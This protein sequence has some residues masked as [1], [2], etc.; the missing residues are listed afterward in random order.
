MHIHAFLNCFHQV[1]AAS[2]DYRMALPTKRKRTE[3]THAIK[4]K[5]CRLKVDR[6]KVTLAEIKDIIREENGLDLGTSTIGD[7]IRESDVWLAI[8]ESDGSSSACR[9]RCPRFL[10]LEDSLFEWIMERGPDSITD[11]ALLEEAK[12]IGRNLQVD[13]KFGY[14]NGWLQRFKQ[15]RGLFHRRQQP[16]RYPK[17]PHR[18]P[19]RPPSLTLSLGTLTEH[20]TSSDDSFFDNVKV[21]T[22]VEDPV[23]LSSYVMPTSGARVTLAQAT[24]AVR[25]VSEYFS[26]IS[27]SDDEEFAMQRDSVVK[28]LDAI[29]AILKRRSHQRFRQLKLTQYFTPC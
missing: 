13:P 4:A 1:P 6:P 2:S 14:S 12:R 5:I 16:P 26:Q 21:K 18:K 25:Q 19:W 7:A 17:K 11:Q 8:D 20:S 10:Q 3:V 9:F 23:P 15:R 27:D 22:E 29:Q 24:F 28:D